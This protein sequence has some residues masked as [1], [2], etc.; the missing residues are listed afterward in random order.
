MSTSKLHCP[1]CGAEAS[2]GDAYC[3]ECGTKLAQ[4]EPPP[5]LDAKE[6]SAGAPAH[7]AAPQHQGDPEQMQGWKKVV[8]IACSILLWP[9]GLVWGLLYLFTGVGPDR[10]SMGKW[11]VGVSIVMAVVWIT[12]DDPDPNASGRSELAAYEVPDGMTLH[13]AAR[14]GN[15]EAARALL[16][17]GADVN[18]ASGVPGETPL[19]EA[20]WGGTLGRLS[21]F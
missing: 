3:V 19:H 6:Q 11:A 2:E 4:A 15:T 20:V 17:Q 1:E 7:A 16:A 14:Q 8:L 9:I 18:A 13:G 10:K 5:P 12:A 21:C